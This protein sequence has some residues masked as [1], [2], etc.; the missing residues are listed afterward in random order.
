LTPFLF[1]FFGDLLDV[2][3][4]REFLFPLGQFPNDKFLSEVSVFA[5]RFLYMGIGA[6]AST[7]VS[8]LCLSVSG[9]RQSHRIRKKYI[10]SLIYQDIGWYDMQR[11]G[12]LANSLG[13]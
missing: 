7:Y 3:G 12:A 10:K 11:A 1:F 2:F 8:I 4:R 5:L 6:F 13:E 9:E